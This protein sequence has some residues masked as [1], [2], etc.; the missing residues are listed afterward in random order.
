[1]ILITGGNGKLGRAVISKLTMLAKKEQIV[2]SVRDIKKA[3]DL[4]DE[5]IQVRQADFADTHSLSN[6][7]EGIDKLFLISADGPAELRIR[8]HK[9]VIDSAKKYG[10]KHIFYTSFIDVAE[11]SPF[12]FSQTH[13]QTESY[14]QASGIAYTILRNNLYSDLLPLVKLSECGNF[15][16]P[17][18]KGKVAFISR[19]DIATFAATILL[20]PHDEH[21]NKIY[22][23]TGPHAYSYFEI[24]QMLAQRLQSPVSYI[25]GTAKHFIKKLTHF[26]LPAWLTESIAGMYLAIGHEQ[27]GYS[28][29]SED[30]EKIVGSPALDVQAWLKTDK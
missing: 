20:Q 24:A 16:L 17:A 14:L 5:G 23:L 26:G 15:S 6:A 13:A 22:K 9:N 28:D 19:E 29:I 8:Q 30:F 21:R 12:I 11:N 2:V 4:I 10:I 25:P 7:F 18:G 27:L 1:M 3:Q